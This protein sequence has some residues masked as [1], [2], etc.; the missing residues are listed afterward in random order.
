MSDWDV[1]NAQQAVNVVAAVMAGRPRPEVA[2]ELDDWLARRGAEL[3]EPE[4][5]RT[6][7]AITG[8]VA[9]VHLAPVVQAGG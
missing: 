6:V 9:V 4:Y 3:P 5:S 1:R 2:A 8:G 7:D